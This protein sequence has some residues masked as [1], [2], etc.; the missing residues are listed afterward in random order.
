MNTGSQRNKEICSTGSKASAVSSCISS[1]GVV[2]N[3]A[4]HH[5]IRSISLLIGLIVLLL[6]VAM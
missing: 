2:R 6:I 5:I 4:T 3:T 1:Q